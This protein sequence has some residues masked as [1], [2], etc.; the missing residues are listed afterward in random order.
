MRRPVE[1]GPRLRANRRGNHKRKTSETKGRGEGLMRRLLILVVACFATAV[2]AAAPALGGTSTS[3][4]EVHA[5]VYFE[6]GDCDSTPTID[7]ESEVGKVVYTLNGNVLQITKFH[8]PYGTSGVVIASALPGYVIVGP[9]EFP[10]DFTFDQ[11]TCGETTGE[12]TTGGATTT[13]GGTTGSGTT[14]GGTTGGGQV[15]AGGT[16]G[17]TGGTTGGVAGAQAGGE[18]PFTGLPVWIPLLAGAALLSGGAL[19]L[20]RKRDE[21]S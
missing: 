12:T 18:L 19:L 6:D 21:P 16:G 13:G 15:S 3:L 7:V 20:R 5:N 14:G 11:A 9:T 10:F 2:L 8:V 4:K 1:A 17:T